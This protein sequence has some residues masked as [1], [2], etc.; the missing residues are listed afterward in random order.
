MDANK[1]PLSDT[2]GTG[3]FDL[4]AEGLSSP[5]RAIES[6]EARKSGAAAGEVSPVTRLMTESE[7]RDSI[8]VSRPLYTRYAPGLSTEAGRA[9]TR[10]GMWSGVGFVGASLVAAGLL[11]LANGG[12]TAGVA[13]A[14]II[15]GGAVA[16]FGWRNAWKVLDRIDRLPAGEAAASAPG[17]ASGNGGNAVALKIAP[18]HPRTALAAR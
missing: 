7:V 4:L 8:L 14:L 13:L 6:A 10:S 9:I 5:P 12:G 15:A 1:V 11:T 17:A 2:G 3:V 16:T 18:A